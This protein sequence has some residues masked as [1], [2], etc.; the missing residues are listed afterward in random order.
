[1]V[2]RICVLVDFG[3]NPWTFE[4][5]IQV[6]SNFC[7]KSEAQDLP[8]RKGM[9]FALHSAVA[10]DSTSRGPGLVHVCSHAITS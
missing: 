4:S 9:S 6:R 10:T 5:T 1:M 3:R 8:I 2:S 7:E